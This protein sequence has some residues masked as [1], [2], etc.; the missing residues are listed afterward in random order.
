MTTFLCGGRVSVCG[1]R[2]VVNLI[3]HGSR[4]VSLGKEQG[5]YNSYSLVWVANK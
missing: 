5:S 2:V 3:M 1:G 4:E